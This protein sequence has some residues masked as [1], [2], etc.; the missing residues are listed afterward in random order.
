MS[1]IGDFTHS[2]RA[3]SGPTHVQENYEMRSGR[4]YDFEHVDFAGIN[5][6]PKHMH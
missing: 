4:S 5:A 1:G 3:I 6:C 2:L